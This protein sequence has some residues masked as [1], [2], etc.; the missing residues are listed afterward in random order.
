MTIIF[1]DLDLHKRFCPLTLTRP[2][3]ELRFG[4][5]TIAESWVRSLNAFMNVDCL[6]YQTEAYL[7]TK[8]TGAN[9]SDALI[10]SGNVKGSIDLAKAVS[11]LKAGDYLTVKGIKVAQYGTNLQ[12]EI[13]RDDLD[14]ITINH[15]WELFQK[16][17]QA[18]KVDFDRLTKGKTSQPLS[19][20]NQV[21]GHNHIFI[22]AG[23]KVECAILNATNGPIYIGADAEVMEGSIIRGPFSLGEH[24]VVKMG[25]KIYG[26]TTIGPHC[27]VG[28]EISNSIFQA[29]SNKGHDGF[30]GNS[31]IGEWCNFGADSNTSNLKNN[32]GN[33]RIFNYES[34]Q[35]EQTE[36]QFCGV[37]MG[38][39]SK[40]SINTMIN[41]GSSVG[42]NVNLFGSDFPPKY[43]PSFSWGKEDKYDLNKA[44]EVASTM[45]ARRKVSLEEEDRAILSHIYEFLA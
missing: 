5:D 15:L 9:H 12:N 43:V 41:T 2:V 11:E 26:P 17:D 38:D 27:K 36:I 23:A 42:V 29:Y 19:A 18:I 35:M 13:V 22:E 33:L 28:G 7:S 32:Y 37:I 10:L 16:N 21:M 44:F 39:H 3:A 6:G 30:V 4:I 34:M 14:L 31:L 1:D 8:F 25:A 40:T 45:M 20:T 24:G